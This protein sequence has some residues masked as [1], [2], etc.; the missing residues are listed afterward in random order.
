M[1]A[2]VPPERLFSSQSCGQTRSAQRNHD[3]LYTFAIIHKDH[4][5]S[6]RLSFTERRRARQ[7]MKFGPLHR[8]ET[9]NTM[10]EPI[11]VTA[12]SFS[13]FR[14]LAE[15][16]IM[17][18]DG[19]NGDL[20]ALY[21]GRPAGQ[22]GTGRSAPGRGA[23]E[24][25]RLDPHRLTADDDTPPGRRRRR[26]RAGTL[27]TR[28]RPQSRA[29]LRLLALTSSTDSASSQSEGLT[30]PW[31]PAARAGGG[32]ALPPR[33]GSGNGA[34]GHGRIGR[35]PRWSLEGRISV[36]PRH[37]PRLHAQPALPDDPAQ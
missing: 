28:Y 18:A 36:G 11:S 37:D 21:G 24:Q 23:P 25:G 19:G 20:L 32:A 22:A 9:R 1:K 8:L 14:T 12:L 2:A 29:N 10:T 4:T 3:S 13:A 5:M 7:A 15:L 34:N 17:Q 27:R 16:G 33:G 6:R 35:R 26:F 31:H 30:S